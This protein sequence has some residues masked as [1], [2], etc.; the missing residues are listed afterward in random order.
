MNYR[1]AFVVLYERFENA[2]ICVI[3]IGL[4][5][6]LKPILIF[7]TFRKKGTSLELLNIVF[8]NSLPNGVFWCN[9]NKSEF[10]DLAPDSRYLQTTA[11]KSWLFQNTIFQ[12]HLS[13]KCSHFLNLNVQS[14]R[15]LQCDQFGRSN[16]L[17][18]GMSQKMIPREN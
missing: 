11:L 16:W 7:P 4:S 5:T 18:V 8:E 13:S 9:K 14:K 12:A 6:E 1:L 3:S 17:R 10:F 2:L 15:T